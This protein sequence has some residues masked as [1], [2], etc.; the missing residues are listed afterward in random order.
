MDYNPAKALERIDNDT[1]LMAMLIDVFIKEC[2]NYIEKLQDACNK[3]DLGSLGDAAHNVKGASAAIGFEHG[4]NL[5]E[6]LEVTC[7]Q[8]GV[9]SIA[10][11]ENSTAK[12][13][14]TLNTCEPIL[15]D[16]AKKNRA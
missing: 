10:H 4:R 8:S 6:E 3:Q 1:G 5:A 2:P 15:N 11:F 7:R 14:E 12:L 16:W 9:K 13:I